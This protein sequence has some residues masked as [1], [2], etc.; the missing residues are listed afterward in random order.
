MRIEECW[1]ALGIPPNSSQDEIKKAYRKKALDTHPDKNNGNDEEFKKINQA[2]NILIGKDK[3]EEPPPS[4]SFNFDP[5]GF[6][7][8]S[9]FFHGFGGHTINQE[10][11]RPPSDD[12][13][14]F[15]ELKI[16]AADIKRGKHFGVEYAKSKN[17]IKCNGVGGDSKENCATCNGQGRFIKPAGLFTISQACPSCMG[18]GKRINNVCKSCDGKGFE[19]YKEV[20][21][22]A[23]KS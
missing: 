5:M 23:I 20:I 11:Q 6:P 7:D 16:S 3:P 2:Y 9:N 10:P 13:N 4:F 12:E 15:F 18:K 22:F 17:C 1:D 19:V 21:R 14:V 8:L